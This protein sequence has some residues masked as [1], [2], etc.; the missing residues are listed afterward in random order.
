VKITIEDGKPLLELPPPY[1]K[2]GDEVEVNIVS[3]DRKNKVAYVLISPILETVFTKKE[4]Q[5]K[6]KPQP[7]SI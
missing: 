2:V 7:S 6:I 5:N 1:D 3:I 4:E